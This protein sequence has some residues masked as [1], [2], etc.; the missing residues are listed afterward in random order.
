MDII[1]KK[2]LD[3][4]L[5]KEEEKLVYKVDK[6]MLYY[7]LLELLD[8]PSDRPAPEMK[9][10]FSYA[11]LPFGEVEEKYLALFRKLHTS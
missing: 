3:S 10:D 5:T 2:Y 9:T 8:E 6:D 4:P 7:D 1:F 11:V